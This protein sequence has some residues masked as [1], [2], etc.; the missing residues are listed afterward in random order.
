MMKTNLFFFCHFIYTSF[1]I[2]LIKS[3]IEFLLYPNFYIRKK[4]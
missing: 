2:F 4:V 3:Y 1:L